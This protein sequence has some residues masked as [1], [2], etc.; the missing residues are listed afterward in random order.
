[1]Y[2]QVSGSSLGHVSEGTFNL[3]LCLCFSIFLSL[4]TNI[5]IYLCLYVSLLISVFLC[6]FFSVSLS[7]A[8]T[9][10][11]FFLSFYLTLWVSL[12]LC[13]FSLFLVLLT[14]NYAFFSFL[15][16][17]LYDEKVVPCLRSKAVESSG[18]PLNQNIEFKMHV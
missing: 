5:Y 8:Y 14:E 17:I 1:M 11:L 13:P 2:G 12:F 15:Y 9:L 4:S 7:L 18:V 10:S 3:S 16:K 6:H